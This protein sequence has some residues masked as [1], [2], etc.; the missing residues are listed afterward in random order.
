ME[1]KVV[2]H[3]ANERDLIHMTLDRNGYSPIDLTGT[4]LQADN[5]KHW[6]IDM[7]WKHKKVSF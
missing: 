2:K 3:S 4:P 5:A 6:P 7:I 1:W